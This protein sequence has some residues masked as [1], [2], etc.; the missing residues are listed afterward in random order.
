MHQY[1]ALFVINQDADLV[2]LL[3]IQREQGIRSACVLA[4]H[5][6]L[7]SER[8]EL[9]SAIERL[10]SLSFADLLTDADLSAC[11]EMATNRLLIDGRRGMGDYAE[12]FMSLSVDEKNRLAHDRL[13]RSS[14]F[15]QVF[16]TAGLGV[17]ASYWATVGSPVKGGSQP[18]TGGAGAEGEVQP[19]KKPLRGVVNF[20]RRRLD[21]ASREARQ[22][23]ERFVIRADG[24][25]YAFLADLKRLRLRPGTVV[26]REKC[27]MK[28]GARLCTTVHQ[29][30]PALAKAPGGVLVFVDGYH[31]SNYPRSYLDGFGANDVF[32]VRTMYD[33]RWFQNFGRQTVKPPP[34]V[35]REFFETCTTTQIARVL[36]ALNHAGDW[37][38]LINRSDTDDLVVWT[39]EIAR[40]LPDVTFR[41][42]M[43]PT[44]DHP[45]HEGLRASQRLDHFVRAAE[46]TNVHTSR[47]SLEADVAWCDACVSEYSQ[48]LLDTFRLGKLGVAVNLTARR[49]F[50]QDYADAG[51]FHLSGATEA[52]RLFPLIVEDPGSARTRQNR[53]VDHYNTRLAEWL[54]EPR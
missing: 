48:V 35:E 3:A 41:I 34:F 29:Y 38:A 30:D 54:R 49:S 27:E 7:P 26:T 5:R 18:G 22:S 36:V 2:R 10:E 53:A 12:R 42:R 6:L 21:T 19:W 24:A 28:E 50:M 16:Y 47:E 1:D 15:R 46:C 8:A 51:F 45:A 31:P 44:M 32:A 17:S 9:L 25:T 23:S 11:D 43:H 13:S 14:R 39:T 37:T 4:T 20:V 33:E 40:R 52:N